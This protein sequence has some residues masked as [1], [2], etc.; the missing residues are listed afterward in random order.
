M[1]LLSKELFSIRN[2]AFFLGQ[3]GVVY[4]Y[5]EQH[6]YDLEKRRRPVYSQLISILT[7][8]VLAYFYLTKAIMYNNDNK[9]KLF[10]LVLFALGIFYAVMFLKD[11]YRLLVE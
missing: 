9:N 7:F 4:T 11:S 1:Y 10:I 5:V 6:I 2:I 3:I 8:V